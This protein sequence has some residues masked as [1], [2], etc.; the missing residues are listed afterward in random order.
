MMS[1]EQHESGWWVGKGRRKGL[2]VRK[3]LQ[4]RWSWAAATR[5]G[6]ACGLGLG[7]PFIGG[8]GSPCKMQGARK[9]PGENERRPSAHHHACEKHDGVASL[10]FELLPASH[11]FASCLLLLCFAAVCS[12]P[13][14]FVGFVA[15]APGCWFSLCSSCGRRC[16]FSMY[17]LYYV[18]LHTARLSSF[19][20]C[21]QVIDRGCYVLALSNRLRLPNM[22]LLHADDH[23]SFIPFDTTA[24]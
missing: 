7:F 6:K 4:G 5:V 10:S 15:P 20:F 18:L 19:H 24:G 17:F 1:A 12:F 8:S 13:L 2:R 3:G 16:P 9:K 11:F 14:Y 21:S 23:S 22:S